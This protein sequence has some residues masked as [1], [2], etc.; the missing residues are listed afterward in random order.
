MTPPD[1]DSLPGVYRNDETGGEIVLDPDGTF[2]ATDISPDEAHGEDGGG[3]EPLDFSGQWK[4]HA[5]EASDDYINLF[6][7]DDNFSKYANIQLYV[8]ERVT[9]VGG[10][11]L[12]PRGRPEVELHPDPDG[13]PT[14]VLTKLP[15]GGA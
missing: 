13:P 11:Q 2:T 10:I 9:T 8:D 5:A 6:T 15:P 14:L 7:K 12:S 1:A 3:A 4:F